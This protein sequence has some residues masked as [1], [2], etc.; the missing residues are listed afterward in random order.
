[1]SKKPVQ[2]QPDLLQRAV[3]Q[4]ERQRMAP[5]DRAAV[6]YLLKQLLLECVGTPMTARSADE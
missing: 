6:V 1:M 5:E 4:A 3:M 2:Q